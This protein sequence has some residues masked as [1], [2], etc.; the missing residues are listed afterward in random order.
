MREVPSV[1]H[2]DLLFSLLRVMYMRRRIE[3]VIRILLAVL[4]RWY[5]G[6]RIGGMPCAWLNG[7]ETKVQDGEGFHY[8]KNGKLE[9]VGSRPRKSGY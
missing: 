9:P 4:V 2:H 8:T 7:K 6:L 5:L 3:I 1:S